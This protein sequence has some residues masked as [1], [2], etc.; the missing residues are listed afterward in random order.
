MAGATLD[1]D[2]Q[3]LGQRQAVNIVLQRDDQSLRAARI[4]HDFFS[5]NP[6]HPQSARFL[7]EWRD[8]CAARGK[9]LDWT[10]SKKQLWLYSVGE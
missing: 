8:E 5:A 1:G 9:P 6:T 2:L 4:Y 10:P 3:P 7:D